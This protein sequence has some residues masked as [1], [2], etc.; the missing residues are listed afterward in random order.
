MSACVCVQPARGKCSVS[1]LCLC[2]R[3]ECPT[4]AEKGPFGASAPFPGPSCLQGSRVEFTV[5]GVTRQKPGHG[6]SRFLLRPS[7]QVSRLCQRRA[8]AS[9]KAKPAACV[10]LGRPFP[11]WFWFPLASG[12]SVW[13]PSPGPELSQE[14]QQQPVQSPA[15]PQEWSPSS[16]QHPDWY[17]KAT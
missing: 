7:P 3:M 1:R 9:R 10:S 6:C 14:S 13:A 15:H 2:D 12:A 11:L 8:L 17:L 16:S 5:S 4:A